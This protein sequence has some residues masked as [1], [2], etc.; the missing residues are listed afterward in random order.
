MAIG[1]DGRCE[2]TAR[3]A[4]KNMLIIPDDISALTSRTSKFQLRFVICIMCFS[5]DGIEPIA[6][7][8]LSF[9]FAGDAV[10]SKSFWQMITEG[11]CAAAHIPKHRFNVDN[12]YHPDTNRLRT[13]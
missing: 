6:I 2:F 7:I 11:R 9:K 12:F 8:G 5:G 3:N 4:T 10:D 13:V 1:L